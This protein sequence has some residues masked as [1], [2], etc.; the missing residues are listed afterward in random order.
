MLT[1]IISAHEGVIPI[2]SRMS[3]AF[4]DF[5]AVECSILALVSDV[6]VDGGGRLQL[7]LQLPQERSGD[8]SAR[9]RGA[10]TSGSVVGSDCDLSRATAMYRNASASR[11]IGADGTKMIGDRSLGLSASAQV[12]AN[13]GNSGQR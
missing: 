8:Q 7:Q 3:N 11:Q 1:K 4:T 10:A 2:S 6:M 13:I 12:R 5:S 9:L